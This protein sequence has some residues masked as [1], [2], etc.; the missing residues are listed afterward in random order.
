M[1]NDPIDNISTRM[2][3]M[4][5]AANAIFRAGLGAVDPV[6]AVKNHCRR[7]DQTLMIGDIR[8][9]LSHVHNIYVIGA[10]K[11]AAS[12]ATAME[13]IMG[14]RIT[15]GA[16]TVKY[17]HGAGLTYIDLM[18]AGHPLPDDN[19]VT[20]AE[21]IL[22]LASAAGPD[23]LII[24]LLS[25]G[26]S[27][28]LPLPAAGIPLGDKQQATQ[29]LLAC[30]A[31]IH[32][33]NTLRKH[34]SRIKG[35][36]LAQAACPA[37]IV[38]LILSDVVGDDLDVIASGPTV[39]DPRTF[40]DCLDIITRHDLYNTLPKTVLDHIEAGIDGRIPETPKPADPIFKQTVTRIIAAN[41]DAVQAAGYEAS[42][43]GFSPLI[44]SSM[45][46]GDT[47]EAA[48]LHTAIAREIIASGHPVG[49]PACI[50][51]GGETTVT[52]TGAGKGGRNQEFVLAAAIDIDGYCQILVF[53]AG[54]D[55]TDGPTDA[56]GA[57]AD[58]LTLSRARQLGLDARR[59]L[60]ENDAYHFFKP[61]DDLI[62]TGP[63]R[64]NV[65]DLRIILVDT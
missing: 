32:E 48:R 17:G 39:P 55:G 43:Q 51:S 30:G 45:I 52:V 28:L 41:I 56:A 27:A 13:E 59:F 3:A 44:L 31:T 54:T 50:L 19:G 1:K 34:L 64:T 18:E 16:V 6:A 24:C 57:V 7:L 25:G 10:G 11:A 53:S 47:T 40:A 2:S 4:R 46:T 5:Q 33:I 21:K 61:L 36:R 38:T 12:M 9:V 8:I 29:A 15:A 23:D 60:S 22:A 14:N 20:G 63:T 49:R 37:R 65:M 62:V 26:G 58:G 35:G 42:R